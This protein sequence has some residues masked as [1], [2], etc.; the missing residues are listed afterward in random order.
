MTDA[1]LVTGG[2][3]PAVRLERILSDPR[4]WCGGR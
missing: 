4:R 2:N 1:T 3:R